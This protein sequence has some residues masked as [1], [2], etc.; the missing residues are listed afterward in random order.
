MCLFFACEYVF[1]FIAISIPITLSIMP[2]WFMLNRMTFTLPDFNRLFVWHDAS[3]SFVVI[4]STD[5][6]K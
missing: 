5:E 3:R 6:K 4:T 2:K 1:G